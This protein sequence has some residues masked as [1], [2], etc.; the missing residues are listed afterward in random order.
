MRR[1]TAGF[2]RCDFH[3]HILRDSVYIGCWVFIQLGQGKIMNVSIHRRC[4]ADFGYTRRIAV[5]FTLI[6]F[7]VLSPRL[8]AAGQILAWGSSQAPTNVPASASN[9]IA[10]SAGYYLNG[11]A[12]ALGADGTIVSWNS[13]GNVQVPAGLSNVMEVASG[14]YQGGLAL[15]TNGTVVGWGSGNLTAL[16]TF[17]NVVS[18]ERDDLGSTLLLAD[19]S[20]ARITF[21]GATYP[22]GL[23]NM[24]A[25]FPFNYGY[26]A[27]R[28]DGTFFVNNEGWLSVTPSNNVMGLA[29]GGYR[30]FQG[31]LLRR[32]RSLVGWGNPTSAPPAG[33]NFMD[34]AASMYGKFVLRTDGTVSGWS[35]AFSTDPTTNF[36]P[37]LTNIT[38]ID[39]GEQHVLAL[40]MNRRFSAVTLSAAVDTTHLVVSSKGSSQWF[41][42]TNVAYDG[43]HAAQSGF[44]GNGTASSM[45]LW[46]IGPVA[47]SFRWRTSSETNHDFLSFSAGGVV[48]T[49]ISGETGWQECSIT[50]P[51][52]NQLLQW[53][54]SKDGAGSAGE[55]AAWVDQV[56]VAPMTPSIITQPASVHALGGS[57]V[58]FFVS[59]TGPHLTYQWQK[60]GVGLLDMTNSS[61]TL[62]QLTRSDSGTYRVRVTNGFGAVISSNAVL[63][64]HVPQRLSI[65]SQPDGAMH[66]YSGDSDG[67]VLTSADVTDF[68]AYISSNLVEWTPVPE[69]L[70]LENGK[71]GLRD[72]SATNSAMRFYLILERW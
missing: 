12:I 51:P 64:V 50:T 35:S 65:A 46:T 14:Y 32:D 72:L 24:V 13:A 3:F 71:L 26:I 49:N 41:G 16:R 8:F 69:A 56:V 15:T 60:D 30:A 18:V 29:A 61:L 5:L 22:A 11:S 45:R 4:L 25:L 68:R 52:G 39:A 2:R 37:G 53:T 7:V 42:Q 34:V 58:T 23:T 59:A 43:V 20:V 27:L 44:I 31:L 66:V 19:G 67:G 57:N 28:A 6:P 40:K 36:P 9:S 55:D 33:T 1:A 17:T 70:I 63:K 10:L 47:V 62:T 48:L 38:V 21:S 54:Y